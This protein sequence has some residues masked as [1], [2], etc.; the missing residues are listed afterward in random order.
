LC[1]L[2]NNPDLPRAIYLY[3]DDMLLIS[4]KGTELL[5]KLDKDS[6]TVTSVNC[7]RLREKVLVSAAKYLDENDFHA[8]ITGK[9]G[10]ILNNDGTEVHLLKVIVIIPTQVC[11]NS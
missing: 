6:K 5:E 9:G 11:M 10:S 8:S 3:V 4:K 1:F 2:T 7:P